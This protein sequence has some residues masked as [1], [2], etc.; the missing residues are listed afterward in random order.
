MKEFQISK[1]KQIAL[2]GASPLFS[3]FAKFNRSKGIR[4]SLISSPAQKAELPKKEKC[5][6]FEKLDH[7]FE[8]FIEKYFDLETTLFLS[9]GAR[10]IFKKRII[11]NVLGGHLL[12][13]HGTRLP[14]DA[15]GA[16]ISWKIMRGD[17]IGMNLVHLVDEGIDSGPIL[18][19]ENFLF[20][21]SLNIPIEYLEYQKTQLLPFYEN[22]IQKVRS[23]EK[24]PLLRQPEYLGRYNPRLK[25]TLHGY[26]DWRLPAASLCRFINAFDDPYPGAMSFYRGKLVHLKGVHLHAGETP[27]HEFMSGL[28]MRHD[29]KWVVIA[30]EGSHSLLVEQV[31]S[32]N[33]ENLLSQ[34][35]A[36]DRFHTPSKYLESALSTRAFFG[37]K[38]EG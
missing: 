20:P 3:Q 34:I 15:G 36:G 13:F 23:G 38:N 11:E 32:E 22:F 6:L 10:W 17:R 30:T 31:L 12:N 28:V 18:D 16:D 8:S 37:S 25:T 27:N 29:K 26:I 7:D 21:S 19:Y 35:R 4:T 2:L 5:W 1:L 14:L 33:G 24:F 9:F